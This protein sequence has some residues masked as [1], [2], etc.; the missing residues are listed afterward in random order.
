MFDWHVLF[1]KLQKLK[2]EEKEEK[3]KKKKLKKNSNSLICDF[4]LK[5]QF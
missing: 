5:N 4:K 1:F 2:K 3:G